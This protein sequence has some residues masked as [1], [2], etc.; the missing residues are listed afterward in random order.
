MHTL[1]VVSTVFACY[2]CFLYWFFYLGDVFD[3]FCAVHVSEAVL[4]L[5]LCPSLASL[6]SRGPWWTLLYPLVFVSL[7]SLKWLS[8]CVFIFYTFLHLFQW[9]LLICRN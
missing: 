4:S 1:A 7:L 6:G 9:L 2:Y 5:S 8:A 3:Y